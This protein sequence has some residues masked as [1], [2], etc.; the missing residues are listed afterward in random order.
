MYQQAISISPTSEIFLDRL[1]GDLTIKGWD[2]SEA[3]VRCDNKEDLSITNDNESLRINCRDD[4]SI[5]VPFAA[6]IHVGQVQG[7][8][9]FK[10]LENHLQIDQINGAVVFHK[11]AEVQLTTVEGDL[12]A[13]KI[14]GNVVIDRVH[15]DVLINH[16]EKGCTIQKV[17]G[18]LH[19]Y[20]IHGDI[21]ASTE[22]DAYLHQKYSNQAS[23]EIIS[24]GDIHCQMPKNIHAQVTLKSQA[25]KI[26]VHLRDEKMLINEPEKS[27]TLGDG[28]HAILLTAEGEVFFSS[29]DYDRQAIHDFEAGFDSDFQDFSK[30]YIHQMESQFEKQMNLLNDHMEKL[31]ET[32]NHAPMSTDEVDRMVERARRSSVIAAQRAQEKMA[33]AQRKLEQKVAAAKRKSEF[34]DSRH[35]FIRPAIHVHW[36][37]K[38]SASAPTDEKVTEDE[39]LMILRMLEQKK[40]SLEEAEKLL[41]ALEGEI[42]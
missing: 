4:F 7:D 19:L 20:D 22:G 38:P 12:M 2:R 13:N 36:D 8:A 21:F 28:T 17:S 35:S 31:T 3:L 6:N 18:G 40:I 30:S 25:N 41:N 33:R 42:G 10:Y 11:V 14:A 26:Q 9:R 1:D 27:L 29:Q 23:C 16:L 15:G 32:L 37:A 5:Y 24:Q 39:R 34:K